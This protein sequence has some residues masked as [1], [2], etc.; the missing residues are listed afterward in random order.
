MQLVAALV[1]TAKVWNQP[2]CPSADEWIKNVSHLLRRL[3]QENRLNPGGGGC[4]ELRSRHCTPAWVT[5]T[6][7]HYVSQVGLK[8]LTSGDASTSASQSA[9]ITDVS[10][11][12]RPVLLLYS[13]MQMLDKFPMEGG[14]KDPKQRIIPFLPGRIVSWLQLKDR[15]Y[16]GQVQWLT[17]V[18]P[19]LWEAEVGRSRGQ[20]FEASLANM[21]EKESSDF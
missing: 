3:R 19:A 18:I 21:K 9:G 15:G 1:T 11:H 17:L 14:Q 4:S 20:E 13:T 10:H 6:G 7:F 5:K 16:P 12:A 2:K 8:L